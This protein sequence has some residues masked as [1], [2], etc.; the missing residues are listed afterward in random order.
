LRALER[1]NGANVL[2]PD[3]LADIAEVDATLAYTHVNQWAVQRVESYSPADLVLDNS[4]PRAVL[5]D[6]DEFL[7]TREGR[8]LLLLRER[9]ILLTGT[10]VETTSLT[11]I[12]KPKIDL[13]LC[14]ENLEIGTYR[15]GD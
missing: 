9:Q 14:A 2:F 13:E 5:S 8:R 1:V 11:Y 10:R 7:H 15:S 4:H 3:G 12:H 6:E